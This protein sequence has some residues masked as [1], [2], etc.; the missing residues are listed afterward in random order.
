M[1]GFEK[2][3]YILAPQ[4]FPNP[5]WYCLVQGLCSG[6][7]AVNVVV[8]TPCFCPIFIHLVICF[9]WFFTMKLSDGI[10]S[11]CQFSGMILLES[12]VRVPAICIWLTGEPELSC[13]SFT[14]LN[15]HELYMR[16]FSP[17]VDSPKQNRA[18]RAQSPSPWCY[19]GCAVLCC[20]QWCSGLLT[21][22]VCFHS[23]ISSSVGSVT[24]SGN[25]V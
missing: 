9:C 17:S 12:S 8:Q 11:L 20:S 16:I 4:F 6:C 15:G 10:K 7:V 2:R 21:S 14:I 25:T 23:R 18:F 13:L 1:P 22:F 3:R 24:S 5:S 19:L